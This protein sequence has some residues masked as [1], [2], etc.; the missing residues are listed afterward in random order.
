M[1]CFLHDDIFYLAEVVRDLWKKLDLI[2]CGAVPPTLIQATFYTY[3]TNWLGKNEE[4]AEYKRQQM[5]A[6]MKSLVCLVQNKEKRN[7]ELEEYLIEHGT[8]AAEV[9]EPRTI[10]ICSVFVFLSIRALINIHSSFQECMASICV[11]RWQKHII[12]YQFHH[13][14]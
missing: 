4:S 8:R 2:I 3:L 6:C 7:K 1:N 9:G 11:R 10:G 14:M 12:I 5:L 13:L